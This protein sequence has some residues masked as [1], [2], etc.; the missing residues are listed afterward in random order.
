MIAASHSVLSSA[1]QGRSLSH[2][3][4]NILTEIYLMEAGDVPATD[5]LEFT[6]ALHNMGGLFTFSTYIRVP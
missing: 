6:Q 4:E 1:L 3:T 2:M 5:L